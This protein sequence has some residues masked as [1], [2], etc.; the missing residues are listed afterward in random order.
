MLTR[1]AK[2][3]Q[4]DRSE[5]PAVGSI[6]TEAHQLVPRTDETLMNRIQWPQMSLIKS[7]QSAST[8]R[9]DFLLYDHED[10]MWKNN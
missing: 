2:G 4:C 3:Y 5:R 10:S 7:A 8:S 6:M 9:P 1:W